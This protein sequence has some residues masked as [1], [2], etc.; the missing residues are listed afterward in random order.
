[1]KDVAAGIESAAIGWSVDSGGLENW[2]LA[3]SNSCLSGFLTLFFFVV[4]VFVV[5]IVFYVVIVFVCIVIVF[6]V[7]VFVIVDGRKILY[8]AIFGMWHLFSSFR[9]VLGPVLAENNFTALAHHSPTIVCWVR[10][11]RS[12]FLLS[13]V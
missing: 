1:M 10:W 8:T 7:V 11:L 9:I 12:L 4:F 13:I 2:R 6:V 5:V 3:I